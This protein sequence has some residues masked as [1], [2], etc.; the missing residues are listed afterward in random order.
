[1][2]PSREEEPVRH[3]PVAASAPRPGGLPGAETRPKKRPPTTYVSDGEEKSAKWVAVLLSVLFVSG[4]ALAIFGPTYFAAQRPMMSP[5]SSP[6]VSCSMTGL[7]VLLGP[8]DTSI[9]S[10][11]LGSDTFVF[12]HSTSSLTM[13]GDTF[14]GGN[15]TDVPYPATGWGC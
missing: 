5:P 9:T 10:C 14:A 2:R 13:Y 1:M 12:C 7:T 8:G 6:P 4:F 15:I 11:A 3:E